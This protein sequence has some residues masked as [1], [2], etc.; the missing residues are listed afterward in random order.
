MAR[1]NVREQLIEAGL[2]ALHQ[3]GFNGCVPKG[4]FYN[5]FESKEDLAIQALERFWQNGAGRRASLSD[6]SVDAVERLRQHFRGLADEIIGH[7]Y[8]RGCLVGNFSQEMSAH[9][10]E[11]RD[12]LA[13]IYAAWTRSLESCVRDAEKAGRVRLRL[14]A[15]D[16]ATFLVNA[17]EGA[18]LRSKVEQDRS[19]LDNFESVVFASIF[20]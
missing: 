20:A 11:I 8:E 2:R 13:A 16:V 3:H 10:R 17:W 18:V 15:A 9:S 6:T 5:H 19:P 12:R 14:P 7:D 1:P 4:S